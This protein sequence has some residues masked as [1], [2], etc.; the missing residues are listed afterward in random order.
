M[1][2]PSRDQIKRNTPLRLTVAA[3]LAFPEG[4][5]TASG[6]GREGASIT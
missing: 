5:M 3:A 6:L 4:S 1:K 2:L